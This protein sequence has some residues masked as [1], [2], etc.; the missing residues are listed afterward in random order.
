MSKIAITLLLTLALHATQMK[1]YNV[2]HP[3]ETILSEP[4][5]PIVPSVQIMSCV[6]ESSTNQISMS[7]LDHENL[8]EELLYDDLDLLALTCYAEA[9]NQGVKGMQYVCDVIL[10]RVD[11]PL[12]PDT[13]PEVIYQEGQFSVVGECL[14]KAGWNITEEAYEAVRLEYFGEERLD[15]EILYFATTPCNGQGHWK[16]KD[17]WFS[18]QE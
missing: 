16:Y 4:C 14:E 15:N 18:Y 1:T 13:I 10:N 9:G 8:E 5:I 2:I 6:E 3:Q 12:F 7:V 17:H 11:S